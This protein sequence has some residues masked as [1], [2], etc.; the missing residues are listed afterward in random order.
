M[1][2]IDD[3]SLV[4]KES[5]HVTLMAFRTQP[6]DILFYAA[7]NV[8]LLRLCAN[9]DFKVRGKLVTNDMEVYEGMKAFLRLV[10]P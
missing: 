5:D 1:G 9:G 2:S 10:H 6:A 7:D 3:A 4:F 8:E